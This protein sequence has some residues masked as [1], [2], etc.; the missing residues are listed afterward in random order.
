MIAEKASFSP[1]HCWALNFL[2]LGKDQKRGGEE[3]PPKSFFRTALLP[4]S[5]QATWED[6]IISEMQ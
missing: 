6:Q 3:S 5:G 4:P 1:S 2:T